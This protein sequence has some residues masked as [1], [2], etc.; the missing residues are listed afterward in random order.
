VCIECRIA[1][2]PKHTT[3]YLARNYDQTTKEQQ[4]D[5]QQYVGGL[6]DIAHDVS[7][8]RFLGPNDLPYSEILVQYGGLRC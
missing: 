3:A 6:E 1:I 8:V 2:V 7:D 4:A 5:I